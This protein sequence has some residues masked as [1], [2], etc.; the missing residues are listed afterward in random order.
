MMRSEKVKDI[1]KMRTDLA[2]ADLQIF[3]TLW[4]KKYV[5][6]INQGIKIQMLDLSDIIDF[7]LI[8]KEAFNFIIKEKLTEKLYDNYFNDESFLELIDKWDN[9]N[10]LVWQSRQSGVARATI[11]D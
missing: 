10:I 3:F 11:P 8:R 2:N 9:L 5:A 1:I 4:L 6:A 7:V